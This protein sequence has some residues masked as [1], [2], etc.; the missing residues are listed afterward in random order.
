[1]STSDHEVSTVCNFCGLYYAVYAVNHFIRSGLVMGPPHLIKYVSA[2][3]TR[4][5]YSSVSPLQEACA[6]GMLNSLWPPT[7]N[8]FFHHHTALR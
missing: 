3:H 7:L 8:Y 4:I 1:M 2:A 5:C 6:V